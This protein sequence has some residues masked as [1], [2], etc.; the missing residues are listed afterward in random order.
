M[1]TYKHSHYKYANVMKNINTGVNHKKT[2]Y[3]STR[4]YT[5]S[6]KNR[7]HWFF[8]YNF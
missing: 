3:N 5:V 7:C 4:I 8:C 2:K 1:K 6:R